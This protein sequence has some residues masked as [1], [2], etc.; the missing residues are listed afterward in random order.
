MKPGSSP[1][2]NAFI[3]KRRKLSYQSTDALKLPQT[4]GKEAKK[5]KLSLPPQN[6]S[7]ITFSK[8]SA[9]WI[10]SIING[11]PTLCPFFNMI[12]CKYPAS[13][14]SVLSETY[15]REKEREIP[16]PHGYV[17]RIGFAVSA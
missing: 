13:Y 5:T 12:S 17:E 6:F 15:E 4:K 9:T 14:V 3:S 10:V 2:I 8:F 11:H 16:I 1:L 7:K